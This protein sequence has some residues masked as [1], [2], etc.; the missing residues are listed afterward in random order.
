MNT[1]K[2]KDK[3]FTTEV[4]ETAEE[5]KEGLKRKNRRTKKSTHSSN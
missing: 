4:A 5:N 1:D 3:I 2:E